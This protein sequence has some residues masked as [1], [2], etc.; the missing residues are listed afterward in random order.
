MFLPDQFESSICR[1]CLL[2]TY[3]DLDKM[4]KLKNQQSV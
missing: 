4:T 3:M 2:F 1:M